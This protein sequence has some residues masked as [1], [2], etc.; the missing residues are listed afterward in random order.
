MTSLLEDV[1]KLFWY[2]QIDLGNGIITPGLAPSPIQL[3]ALRLPEKLD[4][5]TVL[6]VGAWDGFF[7][8]EAERRGAKRVL[9]TD[10]FV[11]AG[12]FPPANKAGF[13]LAKRALGSKVESMVIDVMDLSPE[14]VGTFDIVFFFDVLYHLRHPLYALERLFSVTKKLLLLRTFVDMLSVSRPA[15]AFYPTN[16]LEG[17]ASNWWGPNPAAVVAMLKDVGFKSTEVVSSAYAEVK[18]ADEISQGRIV[19]HA[20]R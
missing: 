13:E 20:A 1:S 8:F 15:M 6:D 14:R 9:A 4:G 11:W 18:A 2:Q 17:D 12:Q 16:E 7:S 10:G 19:V 5:L 3:Q